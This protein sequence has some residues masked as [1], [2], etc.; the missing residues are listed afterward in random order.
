MDAG[1]NP[2]TCHLFGTGCQ[3]GLIY[4]FDPICDV[5][6]FN[7]QSV[8]VAGSEI[9]HDPFLYFD[10][11]V[12]SGCSFFKNLPFQVRAAAVG[13]GQLNAGRGRPDRLENGW[14][15]RFIVRKGD[16]NRVGKGGVIPPVIDG[17][18]PE[19]EPFSVFPISTWQAIK[20]IGYRFAGQLKVIVVLPVAAVDPV[21]VT[22]GIGTRMPG[23]LNAVLAG[24][25]TAA[26]GR[27]GF[28]G[29]IVLEQG[30][31][32]RPRNLMAVLVGQLYPVISQMDGVFI[33][34]P[35]FRLPDQGS[36]NRRK[37]PLSG[38]GAQDVK[39]GNLT[40]SRF[41]NRPGNEQSSLAVV[42]QAGYHGLIRERCGLPLAGYP[43]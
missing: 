37:R 12:W 22:V 34:E 40:F 29:D 17:L 33:R 2:R 20:C 24:Q 5:G 26:Y 23:N 9:R 36:V 8:Q 32:R 16:T 28:R 7:D 30:K 11:G 38:F 42:R 41:R 1:I 21:T 31:P 35:G 3:T 27:R 15:R 25:K 43:C 13:P 6:P 10:P 14:R 19:K 39:S 4:G 18:D